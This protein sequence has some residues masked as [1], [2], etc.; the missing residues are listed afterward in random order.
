ML[1]TDW[2][3]VKCGAGERERMFSVLGHNLFFFD[4]ETAR[5]GPGPPQYGMLTITQN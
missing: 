3:R 4:D 5:S 1:L 2:G